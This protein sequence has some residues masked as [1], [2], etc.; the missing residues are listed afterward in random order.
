MIPR[1]VASDTL[2]APAPL[3][4]PNKLTKLPEFVTK[5]PPLA[6]KLIE[7][8]V[9][10]P[11]TVASIVPRFRVMA[12]ADEPKLESVALTV[13]PPEI[14][15]LPVNVFI[16]VSARVPPPFTAKP[17]EPVILLLIVFGLLLVTLMVGEV[18]ASVIVHVDRLLL[19]W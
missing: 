18:P 9:E 12:L 11:P 14:V 4:I 13:V 16:P 5:E 7:R 3:T 8:F 17:L 6:P 15:T 10:K 2:R 19:I 1:P